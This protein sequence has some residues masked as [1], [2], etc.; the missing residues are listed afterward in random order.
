MKNRGN[1]TPPKKFINAMVTAINES[2]LNE[3][4]DKEFKRVIINVFK[5]KIK[6]V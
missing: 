4:P 6:N 3:I 1:T 5:E 2:E